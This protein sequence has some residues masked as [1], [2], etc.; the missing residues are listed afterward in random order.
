[1]HRGGD[2]VLVVLDEEAQG[3]PP[4]R[5][6]VE[7]LQHGADVHRAVPEVR[8]GHR[9]GPRVELVPGEARGLRD[10]AADDGVRPHRTGFLPLQVHRAAA[11]PAV[12]IGQATYLGEGAAQHGARIV[13]QLGQPRG[14]AGGD[15]TECLGEELVVPPV[16]AV[17]EVVAAQWQH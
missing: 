2:G 14:L 17:D 10:P 5:G 9:V 4:G 15:M 7:R 11:P 3:Q 12:A 13:G 8:H 16:R 1:M 6:E